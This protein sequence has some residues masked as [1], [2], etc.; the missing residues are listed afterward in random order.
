MHYL[1]EVKFVGA[2][3]FR[4]ASSYGRVTL[5]SHQIGVGNERPKS[6]P[7]SALAEV[8]RLTNQVNS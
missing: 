8:Y 7:A 1:T 5:T 4:K 6:I 3:R 2:Y